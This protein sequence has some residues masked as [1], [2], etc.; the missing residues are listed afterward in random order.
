MLLLINRKGNRSF[1]NF[2]ENAVV[3]E[4]SSLEKWGTHQRWQGSESQPFKGYRYVEGVYNLALRA[5]AMF[6][7]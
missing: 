6:E 1:L 7:E 2:V 3:H 4:R 5:F